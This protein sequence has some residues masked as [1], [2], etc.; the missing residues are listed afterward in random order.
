MF[1]HPGLKTLRMNHTFF[2]WKEEYSVAIPEIDE[3]HKSITSMLNTLYE[4]FLKNEHDTKIGGIVKGLASYARYHFAT[5]ERYFSIY[6]YSDRF[7]HMAEHAA[8]IAKVEEFKNDYAARKSDLTQ[9]VIDFLREWLIHHIL[10]EDRK[11]IA[12]LTERRLVV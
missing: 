8:F 10:I 4:A 3:Q 2:P 7:A 12:C 11:Y 5:E 1:T 6:G 9:K